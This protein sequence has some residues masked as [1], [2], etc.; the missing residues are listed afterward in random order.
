MPASSRLILP[1]SS[2]VLKTLNRNAGLR[3]SRIPSSKYFRLSTIVVPQFSPTLT[4]CFRLFNFK[5]YQ[6]SSFHVSYISND[7]EE[8]HRREKC[9]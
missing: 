8:N 7:R 9:G 2:E 6:K 4:L 5:S 3:V 1:R